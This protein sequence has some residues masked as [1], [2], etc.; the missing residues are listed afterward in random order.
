MYKPIQIP[1][2]CQYSWSNLIN[3]STNL[4]ARPRFIKSLHDFIWRR[5]QRKEHLMRKSA[6]ES[7]QKRDENNTSTSPDGETFPLPAASDYDMGNR[8]LQKLA[9]EQRLM[10]REVVV[11]M[12]VGFVGAVMAGVVAD[13]TD[14]ETGEPNYFVIGMQ[15]PSPRSYWKIPYLNRGVAPVEAEDPEVAPLI[16]RNVKEKQTLTAS[17]S[18]EALALADVVVVDVQCDYYTRMPWAMCETVTRISKPWKTA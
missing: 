8:R 3:I 2:L 14:R 1:E 13:S 16:E 15:R 12:G 6:I 9:K 5:I 7:H 11:V 18:F 17:F 10:G 4:A